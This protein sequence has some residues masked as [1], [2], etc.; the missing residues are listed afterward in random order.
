MIRIGTSGWLYREWRGRFY[1]EELRQDDWLPSYAARFPAVEVNNSFYRLPDPE[2]FRRWR[3]RTPAGFSFA[4][5]VSRFLTHLRR[6]RDPEEPWERLWS[7]AVELGPRLGPLLFQLPPR[8]PAD[9]ERLR[10]LLDLL[11]RRARSAFE[12]RDPSWLVPDVFELLERAGAAL[13]WP[14]RPGA[15]QDLPL[16]SGWAY[17]RFHQGQPDAPAYTRASLTAWADRIAGLPADE[18]W[19]FFNND[20]A[21][22]APHDALSLTA[23]LDERG[24]EVL[25]P[26]SAGAS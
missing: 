21:A 18:V 12:F 17:L 25:G 22:A 1:P 23:L 10:G 14:D 15:R 13:V 8:F 19:V 9:V 20:Q 7:R 5:K 11:P 24:A 2:T 4:V 16:V 6:L 26:T 3:E